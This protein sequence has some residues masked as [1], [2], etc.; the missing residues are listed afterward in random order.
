M[1]YV[2]GR[3]GG[4][5]QTINLNPNAHDAPMPHSPNPTGGWP[6]AGVL[7]DFGL[8]PQGVPPPRPRPCDSQHGRCCQ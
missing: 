1:Q 2:G 6:L 3:W 8:H 5:V 7:T 4:A